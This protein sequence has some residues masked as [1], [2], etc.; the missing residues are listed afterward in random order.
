MKTK[1][2]IVLLLIMVLAVMTVAETF[3]FVSNADAVVRGISRANCGT[4]PFVRNESITWENVWTFKWYWTNSYHYYQNYYSHYRTNGWHYNW[5]DCAGDWDSYNSWSDWYQV[6]GLHW[7]W[8]PTSGTIYVGRTYTG[9]CQ[10]F[11][12]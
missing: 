9:W 8:N 4:I 5:S 12:W 11:T 10:I 1:K 3:V 2:S 6:V 7:Y